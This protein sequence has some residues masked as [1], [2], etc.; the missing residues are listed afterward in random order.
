MQIMTKLLDIHVKMVIKILLN[1]YIIYPWNDYENLS[2]LNKYYNEFIKNNK[3]YQECRKF[4]NAYLCITLD[5]NYNFKRACY[6]GYKKI[7][8][9]LY[10]TNTRININAGKNAA[11]R[12][13]CEQG[14]LN[15]AEWL[16]N[17]SIKNNTKINI[18]IKE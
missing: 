18:N 3:L 16:Y 14:H 2:Y 4:C 9:Y 15:I 12:Y 5:N 1:G 8:K 10:K 6:Y 7:V 17:I 11:F 13:S